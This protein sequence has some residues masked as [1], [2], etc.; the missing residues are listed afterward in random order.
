MPLICIAIN[1]TQYTFQCWS[2]EI[3]ILRLLVVMEVMTILTDFLYKKR[4]GWMY[5]YRMTRNC[6]VG[7]FYLS[8]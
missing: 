7:T 3:S 1:T 2:R 6:T 5:L 4:F 8:V